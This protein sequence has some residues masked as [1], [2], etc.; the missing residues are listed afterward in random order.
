MGP[1]NRIV[2]GVCAGIGDYFNL[3]PTIIRVLWI[4]IT[5][6]GGAGILLYLIIALVVPVKPN[7]FESTDYEIKETKDYDDN[8]NE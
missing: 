6:C 2:A 7:T 1:E 8:N 5:L 4:F 3:D